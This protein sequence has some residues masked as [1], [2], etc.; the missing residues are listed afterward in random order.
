MGIRAPGLS[1]SGALPAVGTL[2]GAVG[3]RKTSH[4]DIVLIPGLLRYRVI[5]DDLMAPPRLSLLPGHALPALLVIVAGA[6][7]WQ[8]G[9]LGVSATPGSRPACSLVRCLA[10]VVPVPAQPLL[11]AGHILAELPACRP[12]ACAAAPHQGPMPAHLG[13]LAAP[14]PAPVSTA[15]PPSPACD[16]PTHGPLSGPLTHSPAAAA[17]ISAQTSLAL[18]AGLPELPAASPC[19]PTPPLAPATAPPSAAGASGL[20][21]APP[22]L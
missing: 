17:H 9:G 4:L 14:P 12:A 19:C 2:T 1:R 8:K 15:Q 22:V 10:G 13:H 20:P 6:A 3:R 21:P 5:V 11:P 16:Q 7:A 18:L